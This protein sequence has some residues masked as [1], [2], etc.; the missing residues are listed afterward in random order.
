MEEKL[1]YNKIYESQIKK[2]KKEEIFNK[3]LKEK[4]L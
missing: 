1:T 2:E 3:N 4:I